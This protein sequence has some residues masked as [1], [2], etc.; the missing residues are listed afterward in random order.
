M[1]PATLGA[2]IALF[3][4]SA[5]AIEVP[6]PAPAAFKMLAGCWASSHQAQRDEEFWSTPV[7][8]GLIGMARGLKDGNTLSHE[9]TLPRMIS[10]PV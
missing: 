10:P 7:A 5:H 1:K 3:A 9:S 8:D 2:L 4:R 6:T